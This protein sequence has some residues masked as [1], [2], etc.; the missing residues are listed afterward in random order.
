MLDDVEPA[1]FRPASDERSNKNLV[2]GSIVV[3]QVWTQKWHRAGPNDAERDRAGT[4]GFVDQ[5]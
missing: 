3:T 2:D 1:V 4:L 5:V